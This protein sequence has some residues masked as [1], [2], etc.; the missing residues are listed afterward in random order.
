MITVMATLRH[1]SKWVHSQ[2]PLLA[3]DPF[4]SVKDITEDFPEWKGLTDREIMLLKSACDHR[5]KICVRKDQN[6]YLEAAVLYVLL[7][8][9]L[10]EAE[11]CSLDLSQYHHKGFHDVK[12]KGKRI[13]KKVPLPKPAREKLD[14]YLE[15]SY[16]KNTAILQS[17]YG[18]RIDSR[19]IRRICDRIAKQA[20]AHLPE[21][22]KIHLHPHKLRHTFL[23]RIADKEGVHNAHKLSG[24]ITTSIIYRYTAPSQ[25]E[26]DEIAERVFD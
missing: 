26:M 1:F 15:R 19:D 3:G 17:R 23:K 21:D 20:S 8:T 25:K 13:T 11:L 4:Q 24:N 18:N 14:E 2:R 22:E 16:G 6:P 5:I 10:R 12:R 9:G 7:Y